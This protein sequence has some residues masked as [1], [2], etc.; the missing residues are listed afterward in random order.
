MRSP[1]F[2]YLTGHRLAAACSLI[3]D[4]SRLPSG[5]LAQIGDD[6]FILH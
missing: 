5:T 6:Q 1:T 3:G 2:Q 4:F